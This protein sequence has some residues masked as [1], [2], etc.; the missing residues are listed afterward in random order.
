MTRKTLSLKTSIDRDKIKTS[1]A[2][3]HPGLPQHQRIDMCLE[4]LVD[5]LCDEIEGK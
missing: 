2:D 5:A 3:I 1:W 4:R